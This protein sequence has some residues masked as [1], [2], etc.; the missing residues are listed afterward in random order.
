MAGYSK[1][2][3]AKFVVDELLSKP[4]KLST[5]DIKVLQTGLKELG[6]DINPVNGLLGP[7]TAKAIINHL[8]KPENLATVARVSEGVRQSLFAQ[9]HE[10]ALNGLEKQSLN[11]GHNPAIIDKSDTVPKL[12]GQPYPLSKEEIG[13]LQTQLTKGGFYKGEI[14]GRMGSGTLSAIEGY[15]KKNPGTVLENP[16]IVDY[17]QALGD[18]WQGTLRNIAGASKAYG[19]Q[20]NDLIGNNTGSEISTSN[21][22]LQQMLEAGAYSPRGTNPDGVIGEGTQK[23][24]DA[25]KNDARGSKLS[26]AWDRAVEGPNTQQPTHVAA[27]SML[28]PG[29]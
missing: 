1:T 28:P 29:A 9:G 18:G 2:D 23:A 3:N 17:A 22:R 10:Q 8:G 26:S 19:R 25:F 5:S 16:G 6:A 14:D 15:V 27:L 4:G 13:H 11:S 24:I 7:G 12:L 21:Y 20:V